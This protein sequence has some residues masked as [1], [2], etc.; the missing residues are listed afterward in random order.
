M[1]AFWRDVWAAL[2]RRERT[3]YAEQ[4]GI[5]ATPPDI[6]EFHLPAGE[7][8]RQLWPPTPWPALTVEQLAYRVVRLETEVGL[9]RARLEARDG[10]AS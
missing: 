3:V 8:W 6:P 7:G 9:L 2:Q 4:A 1:K 10:P 5:G